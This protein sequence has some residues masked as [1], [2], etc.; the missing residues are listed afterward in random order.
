VINQKE[1]IKFM[2]FTFFLNWHLLKQ[3][4]PRRNKG[5]KVAQSF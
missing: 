2:T 3:P 4:E 1:E 5:H